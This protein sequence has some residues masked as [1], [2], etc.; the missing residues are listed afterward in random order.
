MMLQQQLQSLL[1]TLSA[2]EPHYIRCI[3]P[4]NVLKPAIFENS[5]VLQQLRCGVRCDLS[6]ILSF[7]SM[8]CKLMCFPGSHNEVAAAKVLLEKANLTGYQVITIRR[9]NIASMVLANPGCKRTGALQ[10][11]KNKLEKEVE[12]LTWQLELEKRTKLDMEES[13]AQEI[14]NLQLQLHELQLQVKDTNELLNTKQEA[15]KEASEKVVVVPKI[16]ADTTFDNDLT[17]ENE[18]LKVST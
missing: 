10:A 18:R 13:K 6:L 7:F 9:N 11:A 12:E 5:D 8:C 15:T 1:E 3:K 17:A 16:L 14:K 4:N 2:T